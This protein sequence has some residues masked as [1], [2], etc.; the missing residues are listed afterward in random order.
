MLGD[1]KLGPY[2]LGDPP[3][4]NVPLPVASGEDDDE[5][6]PEDIPGIH[7]FDDDVNLRFLVCGSASL[8]GSSDASL[9]GPLQD[10][11]NALLSIEVHGKLPSLKLFD[12]N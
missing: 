1:I 11:L 12:V 8:L 9:L 4:I 3:K 5:S 10:R 6:Y 2:L 7:I